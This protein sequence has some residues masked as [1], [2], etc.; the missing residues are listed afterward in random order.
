MTIPAAPVFDLQAI[1]A[2]LAARARAP[3]PPTLPSLLYLSDSVRSPDPLEV[4][5]SLPRGCGV[6]LRHYEDRDRG[7]LAHALAALCR[8][9]GLTFLVAADAALA[10]EVGADGVHWPE[11]LLARQKLRPAGVVT[12]SA[13]GLDGLNAAA[14]H[15]CD[16]AILSPVFATASH[17][18]AAPLGVD[19][20]RALVHAVRLP[21]LALGGI[22]AANA[23]T[24]VGS[25]AAGI[26]AVGA[27]AL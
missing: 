21:V 13:H 17:P 11:A 15:R 24:L 1:A 16:A 3:L 8:T 7:K 5:R 4:A 12:A 27:F 22:T 23:I 14:A 26:A 9:R 10:A 19:R 25:G 20:F 2:R 6:V 18:D